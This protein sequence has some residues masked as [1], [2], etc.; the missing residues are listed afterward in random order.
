MASMTSFGARFANLTVHFGEKSPA[1]HADRR[2]CA[3]VIFSRKK[4]GG[5]RSDHFDD[6]H[7]ALPRVCRRPA[8]VP[9]HIERL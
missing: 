4:I 1:A 7:R 9:G 3:I 5:V 8:G 2:S 6:R